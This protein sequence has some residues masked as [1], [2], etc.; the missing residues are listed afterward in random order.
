MTWRETSAR[1]YCPLA[2]PPPPAAYVVLRGGW[3]D[4]VPPILYVEAQAFCRQRESLFV[5]HIF[6]E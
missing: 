5:E 6:F 1:P 2:P 4:V 3:V